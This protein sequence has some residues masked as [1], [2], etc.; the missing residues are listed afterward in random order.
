M[1]E[2]GLGAATE[3]P[4]GPDQGRRL[5]PFV[6]CPEARGSARAPRVGAASHPSRGGTGGRDVTRV[7]HTSVYPCR[8]RVAFVACSGCSLLTMRSTLELRVDPAGLLLLRVAWWWRCHFPRTQDDIFLIRFCSSF[9]SLVLHRCH[10]SQEVVLQAKMLGLANG[11]PGEPDSAA[12]FLSQVTLRSRTRSPVILRFSRLP[13]CWCILVWCMHVRPMSAELF[14]WDQTNDAV[15]A[16]RRVVCLWRAQ[17]VPCVC[18]RASFA[19][20]TARAPQSLCAPHLP[21]VGTSP[22]EVR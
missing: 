4:G 11:G 19:Q 13:S 1:G 20:S 3:G 15:R 22:I 17:L 16:S 14:S 2:Q 18:R 12:G 10:G 8:P 21:P 7:C 5:L 6:Q 9:P